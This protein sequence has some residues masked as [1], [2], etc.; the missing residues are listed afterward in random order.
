MTFGIESVN[1]ACLPRISHIVLLQMYCWACITSHLVAVTAS[2]EIRALSNHS[3]NFEH[4]ILLIR[5]I[6]ITFESTTTL[7]RALNIRITGEKRRHFRLDIICSPFS[8][9][10]T[11]SSAP[12]FLVRLVS[13]QYFETSYLADKLHISVAVIYLRNKCSETSS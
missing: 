8:A 2:G 1:R 7:C 12:V 9:R 4:H 11:D 10:F 3:S 13:F 6:F 5:I